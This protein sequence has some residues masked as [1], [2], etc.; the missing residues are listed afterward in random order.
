M[1]RGGGSVEFYVLFVNDILKVINFFYFLI[2]YIVVVEM[3]YF[4]V[5]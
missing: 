3:F 1:R 4:R 2:L 5:R